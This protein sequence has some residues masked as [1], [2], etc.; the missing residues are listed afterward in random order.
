[1]GI[2]GHTFNLAIASDLLTC[3][4]LTIVSMSA[5]V[6]WAAMAARSRQRTGLASPEGCSQKV[7]LYGIEVL[8][9]RECA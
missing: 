2:M 9:V 3:V 8:G 4:R 6:G 7:A 5:S 1:M